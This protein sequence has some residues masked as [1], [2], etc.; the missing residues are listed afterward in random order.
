[1][2][3]RWD[4][5]S[6]NN[7]NTAIFERV[8]APAADLRRKCC[9]CKIDPPVVFH[10]SLAATHPNARSTARPSLS[11]T[12]NSTNAGPRGLRSPRSQ[13]LSVPRLIENF[14]ANACCEFVN[15]GALASVGFG[16]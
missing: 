5:D 11:I 15:C 10:D 13:C 6:C 9:H 16:T 4:C 2:W 1:M 7:V 8:P 14:A 12:R 3:T